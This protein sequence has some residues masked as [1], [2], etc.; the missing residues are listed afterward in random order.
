MG[1]AVLVR[2][3]RAKFPWRDPIILSPVQFAVPLR[4]FELKLA[5][6]KEAS[7]PYHAASYQILRP[8]PD[9]VRPLFD[10]ALPRVRRD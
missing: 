8:L 3:Y 4:A 7:S 5:I 2:F 9:S 1:K 10:D 6:F